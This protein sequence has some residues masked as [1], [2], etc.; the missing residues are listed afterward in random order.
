MKRLY[1]NKP[2]FMGAILT[3]VVDLIIGG[4][5]IYFKITSLWIAYLF[6]LMGIIYPVIMLG[7]YA[8]LIKVSVDEFG[9]VRVDFLPPF[10]SPI[11]FRKDEL[12]KLL[13]KVTENT[14]Y[15]SF[16]G[17]GGRVLGTIYRLPVSEAIKLSKFLSV[18]LDGDVVR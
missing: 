6:I 16:L 4:A 10:W 18:P 12:E 14:F 1:L 13:I 9:M 11:E 17:R 7:M 5:I 2:L 15:L 3:G 8:R